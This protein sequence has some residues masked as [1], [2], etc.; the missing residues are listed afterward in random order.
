MDGDKED[1]M[2]QP[3]F[4]SDISQYLKIVI[5]WNIDGFYQQ[6]ARR[7]L[8]RITQKKTLLNQNECGEAVVYG[9][10]IPG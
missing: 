7:L 5:L 3:A 6:I 8:K 4:G 1:F 9:E 2:E 10:V